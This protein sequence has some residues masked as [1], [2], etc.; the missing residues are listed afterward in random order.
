MRRKGEKVIVR[1][2]IEAAK[3]IRRLYDELM[4]IASTRDLL[5]D[6]DAWREAVDA[7]ARI[8]PTH[9]R[10]NDAPEY[11]RS[12]RSK[13]LDYLERIAA[14]GWV[15]EAALKLRGYF[16]LAWVDGGRNLTSDNSDGR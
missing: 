16:P 6:R 13:P 11:M 14:N 12:M 4:S 5:T 8:N 15:K 1:R 9:H 10:G 2:N 3:H 7:I